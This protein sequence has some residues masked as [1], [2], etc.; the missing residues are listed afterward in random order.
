VQVTFKG[1][2]C[3][4]QTLNQT[5]TAFLQSRRVDSKV[6]QSPLKLRHSGR[7]GKDWLL[8][9]KVMGKTLCCV[10][11]AIDSLGALSSLVDV[12][13]RV[14]MTVCSLLPLKQTERSQSDACPAVSPQLGAPND[15]I[16]KEQRANVVNKLCSHLERPYI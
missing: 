12:A 5:F 3:H 14:T 2:S 10:S 4:V 6:F 9:V 16:E 11:M 1:C 13:R 15:T 8:H 7:A